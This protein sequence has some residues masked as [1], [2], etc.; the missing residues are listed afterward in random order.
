MLLVASPFW[1]SGTQ[2]WCLRRA[3]ASG[4]DSAGSSSRP[5]SRALGSR[6]SCVNDKSFTMGLTRPAERNSLFSMQGA[7]WALTA[8]VG[9]L[10]HGFL[11]LVFAQWLGIRLEE[12][13]PY[14][15]ALSISTGLAAAAFVVMTRT[16]GPSAEVGVASVTGSGR[17]PVALI[18]AMS[19]VVFFQAAG[20]SSVRTFFNVYLDQGLGVATPTIGSLAALGALVSAFAALSMPFFAG[21]LGRPRTTSSARSRLW[22]RYSRSRSSPTCGRR[23]S[24]TSASSPSRRSPGRVTSSSSSSWCGR[25]GVG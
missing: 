8:F 10:I 14:R 20:E 3:S 6:C 2:G 21:R 23:V 9:G 17:A 15:D 19:L 1:L 25:S 24:D 5:R 16:R 12:P 4:F 7:L 13:A 11:P 18:L 22:P